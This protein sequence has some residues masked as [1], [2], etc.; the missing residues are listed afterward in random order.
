MP[1]VWSHAGSRKPPHSCLLSV[2]GAV[3]QQEKSHS[4]SAMPVVNLYSF[5]DRG[6]EM[7]KGRPKPS[8][9]VIQKANPLRKVFNF[10]HTLCNIHLTFKSIW[11]S[12]E[13]LKNVVRK[14]AISIQNNNWSRTLYVLFHLV[15]IPSY[16]SVQSASSAVFGQNKCHKYCLVAPT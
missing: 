13:V 8:G 15:P 9:S 2:I 1:L 16:F 3:G 4:F 10:G 12:R 14:D 6:L 11:L 7:G 5:R